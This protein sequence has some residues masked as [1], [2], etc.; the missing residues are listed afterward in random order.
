MLCLLYC[1]ISRAER[2]FEIWPLPDLRVRFLPFS[3]VCV[4]VFFPLW[5][6]VC[7]TALSRTHTHYQPIIM[8]CWS[9][10]IV[11]HPEPVLLLITS[12]NDQKMHHPHWLPVTAKKHGIILIDQRWR[13]VKKWC[14]LHRL[15]VK[16]CGKDASSVPTEWSPFTRTCIHHVNVC[17]THVLGRR[18][19]ATGN[20]LKR[21]NRMRRDHFISRTSCRESAKPWG[22]ERAPS[23]HRASPL[24]QEEIC[25][26]A[27]SSCFTGRW[28]RCC[29]SLGAH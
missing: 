17:G 26:T 11:C 18:W 24:P 6:S 20:R 16:M 14:H 13:C 3:F 4:S 7:G 22:T 10:I 21:G 12:C 5:L 8:D 19:K 23:E 15:A 29:G 9:M 28:F 2:W 25:G 27:G 1:F